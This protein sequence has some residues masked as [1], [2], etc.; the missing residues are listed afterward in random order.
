MSHGKSGSAWPGI[1]EALSAAERT[2]SACRSD[3]SHTTQGLLLFQDQS[4]LVETPITSL[5]AWHQTSGFN[6]PASSAS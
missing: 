6:L 2:L 4:N 5:A 3:P 1:S